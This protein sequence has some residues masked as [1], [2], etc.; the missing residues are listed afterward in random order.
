MGIVCDELYGECNPFLVMEDLV[1]DKGYRK[2]G[3]GRA[4]MIELEKFAKEWNCIQI[5]FV[6]ESDR[7]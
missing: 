5:L 3:I 6:T 4:L 1:V 2:I 7:A